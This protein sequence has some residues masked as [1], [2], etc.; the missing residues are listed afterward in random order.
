MLGASLAGFLAVAAAGY[1]V[2]LATPAL[3]PERASDADSPESVLAARAPDPANGP[4]RLQR[5]YRNGKKHGRWSEFFASGRK[6]SALEYRDGVAD[7]RWTAWY[8]DGK[9][10]AEGR[11]RAGE[12]DGLWTS[13]H[14]NGQ[15][16]EQGKYR[17]GERHGVWRG[18]YPSGAKRFV[19]L[20]EYG[21]QLSWNEWNQTGELVNASDG[22]DDTEP[23]SER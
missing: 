18:W 20:H 13:W 21:I 10:R 12:E 22:D 14:P 6:R 8:P 7:G 19:R 5:E 3:A 16:A 11:Y 17:G 2:W 9:L 1:G 15:R 4:S 23:G